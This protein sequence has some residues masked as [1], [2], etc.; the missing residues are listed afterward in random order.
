MLKIENHYNRLNIDNI[1]LLTV[2]T[3]NTYASV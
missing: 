3:E 1:K 2:K